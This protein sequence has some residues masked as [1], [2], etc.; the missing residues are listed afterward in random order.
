MQDCVGR[1]RPDPWYNT[2]KLNGHHNPNVATEIDLH[3]FGLP[4]PHMTPRT[5]NTNMKGHACHSQPCRA[6][7][8]HLSL[9]RG[10][11]ASRGRAFMSCEGA[12]ELIGRRTLEAKVRN[13]VQ[14]SVTA[15]SVALLIQE[16][17]SRE[18]RAR[19]TQRPRTRNQPFEAKE[20]RPTFPSNSK[21]GV[22][23]WGRAADSTIPRHNCWLLRCL[24]GAPAF[25]LK[26]FFV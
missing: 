24:L 17:V 12:T 16:S 26:R 23:L 20:S 18:N 3:S 5:H 22:C 8:S 14:A 1:R 19:M 9:S 2:E 11:I 15:C 7:P 13:T 10:S 25:R 6:P 4:T 21:M